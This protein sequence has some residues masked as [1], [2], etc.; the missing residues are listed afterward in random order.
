MKR[1]IAALVVA[2]SVSVTG[3]SQKSAVQPYT[4]P[5]QLDV[6]WPKHSHYKQPW[7]GFLETRSGYDF[8]HGIG[9]NYNVPG[10]DELAVRLLA[11]AGFKTFRIEIG[12]GSVRWDQTGLSNEDRMQRL[13]RLC[14]QYAIRPTFLLNAHQ[15][16]PCP[17][18]LFTK[19]LVEDAPQGRRTIKLADTRNLVIGRSGIN[20]LTD[21]WAAEALIT[22]VDEKT[23]RCE[24]SKP[25]PKELKA[26][27]LSM[28]TLAYLP[29]YPAGTREFDETAAGWA[30]YALTVCQLARRAGIDDFDVEIWNELTFG[31]RF[32]DINNY[33]DQQ[34]PKAVPG[35][36]ALNQGGRCWELA[37][38]TIEA[39]KRQYPKARLIWGFSNTTFFHCPI[40]RLPPGTDGQSYHPYGTGTRSLPR[41][42]YYKDHSELNLEGFTPTIDIRMPEGWAHTFLQTE[43]L[44]R[45]LNPAARLEQRPVGVEHFCHYITE[46]GVV[47]AEC[48]IDNV[49]KGWNLKTLCLTRSLCLW[50]NK[51]VDVM[52]YFAAYE[53]SPL[54]MGLLPT[55]LPKLP[56]ESKFER[57]ATAPMAVLRNLTRALADSVPLEKLRPL[58]VE[59]TPLG[60]EK[61]VFAGDAGHPPLRHRDVVAVLPF[62]I[63]PDKFAIV[64]YVMTYDATK[65]I[66]P[67]D[68]RL[69]IKGVQGAKTIATLYDPQEDTSRRLPVTARGAASLDFAV[70]L[71]DHPRLLMLTE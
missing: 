29:L 47:P 70:P 50:L 57:V 7:R 43:S 68:Y 40:A 46:H 66:G 60:E 61:T 11:E 22:S 27:D 13:L 63:R 35:P 31:T 45:H 64:V 1:S 52:H 26:G 69:A 16:V 62:Q 53:A 58:S 34:N 24:L 17:T 38:R 25:L 51:G 65:P 18:Q 67:E 37:R 42:E 10:N 14:K 44:M 36:D 20:G 19:R 6:P 56:S 4:D 8:L 48:G 23:G 54:G 71:V 3:G 49:Q 5:G 39:V 30:R 15:G 2:I 32:L 41:Q 33:Y 12:F 21:Y 9:V 55:D 28:A 59:I